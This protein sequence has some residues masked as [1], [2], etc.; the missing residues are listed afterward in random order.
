MGVIRS[1]MGE[2][3]QALRVRCLSNLIHGSSV[4]KPV[5][6]TATVRTTFLYAEDSEPKF[7]RKRLPKT[8]SSV[9]KVD[10]VVIINQF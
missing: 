9:Y 3:A 8:A 4:C 7:S 1:A 10:G 6:S 5:G 2:I